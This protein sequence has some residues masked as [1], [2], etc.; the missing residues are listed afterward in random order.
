MTL[1]YHTRPCA[2]FLGAV[3]A[4]ASPAFAA[5]TD[6]QFALR[7]YGSH[8]CESFLQAAEDP[9]QSAIYAS[10]LMGYLT[11]KNRFEPQVFDVLP[12]P[13]G[14]IFLDAISAVCRGQRGLNVEQAGSEVIRAIGALHQ[15]HES[16]VLNLENEGRKIRIRRAALASLQGKLSSIGLYSGSADGEWNESVVVAVKTFQLR[17]KIIATGLPDLATLIRALVL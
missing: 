11:A 10:W 12:F 15:A 13:D 2:V 16:P 17:E 9:E 4:L 7:G 8:S 3:L 5:D 14:M 1:A 6:G